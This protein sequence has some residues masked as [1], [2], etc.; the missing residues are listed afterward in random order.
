MLKVLGTCR[1]SDK[2]VEEAREAIRAQDYAEAQLLF[3]NGSYDSAYAA[4]RAM[5]D[6]KDSAEWLKTVRHERD[7]FAACA[8]SETENVEAAIAAFR[9]LGDYRDSAEKL[10]A[11]RQL[12]DYDAA[13]AL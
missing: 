2:R 4:F 12:R 6:Y 9:A 10:H 5:G 11:L 7:Y 1:D 3:E 8:L 13:R